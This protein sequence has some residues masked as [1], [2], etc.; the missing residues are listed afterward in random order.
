[1]KEE[2]TNDLRKQLSQI[3]TLSEKQKVLQE[4]GISLPELLEKASIW[5]KIWEQENVNGHDL[6][7]L[8]LS[9]VKYLEHYN[10][11]IKEKVINAF[12]SMQIHYVFQMY[13]FAMNPHYAFLKAFEKYFSNE[14]KK[15]EAIAFLENVRKTS[16]LPPMQSVMW[17]REEL[18]IVTE[19][20]GLI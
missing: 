3:S 7:P 19:T 16:K 13:A 11:Q 17:M 14:D 1:M 18:D 4:A 2:K 5:G 20:W 12:S 6:R 15:K 9:I 8:K 10:D